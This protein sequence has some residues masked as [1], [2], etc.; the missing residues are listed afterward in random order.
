MEKNTII[1]KKRDRFFAGDPEKKDTYTIFEKFHEQ[2]IDYYMVPVRNGL[3]KMQK[4]FKEDYEKSTNNQ[5]SLTIYPTIQSVEEFLDRVIG[6]VTVSLT[7]KETV[8]NDVLLSAE[9]SFN[10]ENSTTVKAYVYTTGSNMIESP[11]ERTASMMKVPFGSGSMRYAYYFQFKDD[12]VKL[13]VAKKW[14]T[15]ENAA[16]T[17]C[18]EQINCHEKMQEYVKKFNDQLKTQLPTVTPLRCLTLKYMAVE[19]AEGEESWYTLEDYVDGEYQKH[20]NNYTYVNDKLSCKYPECQAFPHFTF[21]ES[22]YKEMVVDIQGVSKQNE[23]VLTDPVVH[24]I[25]TKGRN[26]MYGMG[27]LGR[28]GMKAFFQSHRCNEICKK[29][30]LKGSLQ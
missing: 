19:E 20:N 21:D 29:L 11:K 3:E 27:D 1:Q 10:N 15:Q 23:H 24:S 12:H 6:S 18:V 5:K 28:V 26:K 16:R 17:R 2:D 22:M 9:K 7:G 14:K 25:D 8:Y 4:V 13:Y 30:Q